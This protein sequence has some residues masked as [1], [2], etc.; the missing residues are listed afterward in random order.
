MDI[1]ST[2]S[3]SEARNRFKDVIEQA[4]KA[5]IRVTNTDGSC[6][7]ILNSAEYDHLIT[8]E[9]AV[10]G[11]RAKAADAGGFLGHE[12]SMALIRSRLEEAE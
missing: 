6:V 5:P 7:V 3:L 10:W 11:M 2:V 4:S 8:I 1:M 12:E 9:D